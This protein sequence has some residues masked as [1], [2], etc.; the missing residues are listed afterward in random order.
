[1]SEKKNHKIVLNVEYTFYTLIHDLARKMNQSAS[2]YVR[3]VML[4]DLQDRG[5]ITDGV[6]RRVTGLDDDY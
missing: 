1:M 3:E 4:R 6:L 2:G 5:V